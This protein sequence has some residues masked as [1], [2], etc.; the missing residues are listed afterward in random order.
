MA[1]FVVSV[2]DENDTVIYSTDVDFPEP[3]PTPLMQGRTAVMAAAQQ[4]QLGID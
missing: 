3:Q 2:A 4:I 1:R